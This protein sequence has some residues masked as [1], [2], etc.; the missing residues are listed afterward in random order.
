MAGDPEE[1]IGQALRAQVGGPARSSAS[2]PSAVNRGGLGTV[3]V[4][5]IAAI[6]GL[7]VGMTAGFVILLV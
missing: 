5:L 4:L 7:A 1:L 2:L 6:I 3:P